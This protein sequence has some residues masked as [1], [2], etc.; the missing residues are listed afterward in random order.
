VTE[1]TAS[2]I[3]KKL[4]DQEKEEGDLPLL[5][6]F[7]RRLLQLQSRAQRRIVIP[8]PGLSHEA[9]RM[10]IQK[11]LPLLGFDDLT[12]DWPLVQDTFTQVSGLFAGYPQLFGETAGRLNEACY[13]H[14]LTRKEV[15]AWFTGK[16]LPSTILGGASE[17][18]MLAIIQATLQPFLASYAQVLLGSVEQELW[19]RDYC[20]ICGGSPDLASLK[21]EYG[22]RWLLCSRCDTEWLF[23]RLEC[24]YCGTQEQN[25]LAFFTDDKELYRLYVCERCKCY[26]KAVDLRKTKADVL[27]PL[28]RLYTIDLD[29][30]ARERGYHS[31]QES[32]VERKE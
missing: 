24:P 16:G 1:D 15:E 21:G 18:L 19:R 8:A 10:R 7:Y 14:V 2:K 5:L 22:I 25:A 28:E 17:N 23:K 29:K 27:L 26:L 9:I 30:Q 32:A 11:G 13:C 6:E 31:Y 4:E 3:L 20:P 12:L